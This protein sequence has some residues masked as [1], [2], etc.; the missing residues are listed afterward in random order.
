MKELRRMNNRLT[1]LVNKTT[2]IQIELNQLSQL[3][4]EIEELWRQIQIELKE[5]RAN[6]LTTDAAQSV[7]MLETQMRDQYQRALDQINLKLSQ[8]ITSQLG[9]ETEEVEETPIEITTIETTPPDSLTLN[10]VLS[11]TQGPDQAS[12][13]P[14]IPPRNTGTIPKVKKIDKP[15]E[16][17]PSQKVIIDAMINQIIN[18]FKSSMDGKHNKPS[19][20][21]PESKL[22]DTNYVVTVDDNGRMSSV[23]PIDE[24]AP[25]DL[26]DTDDDKKISGRKGKKVNDQTQLSTIE[27]KLDK[28]QLQ[29][30][31][32]DW[33]EW[34][35]FRDQSTDL[36]HENPRLEK[37]QESQ[38]SHVIHLMHCL[39]KRTCGAIKRLH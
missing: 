34:I 39:C 18:Q 13:S 10:P 35:T 2:D 14:K 11:S 33:T 29:T 17:S 27:L 25:N 15:E 31:D 19:T 21:K 3:K 26:V 7:T 4:F 8:V 23:E 28:I 16:F 36:V 30:F 32:G 5:I 24:V 12:K 20:S 6:L 9:T 38:G 1:K 22:N 37:S